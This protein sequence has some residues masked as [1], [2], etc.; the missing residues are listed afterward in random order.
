VK[1][2][3]LNAD[4]G[5][6]D[7]SEGYAS[8]A[9]ILAVV[10]SASIACGGHAGT[11]ATMRRAVTE[12]KRHHV[13]IGAHPAYPD[14]DYFGRRSG[15]DI[16]LHDLSRSLTEQIV[17][18]VEIAAEQGASVAYVKPHGAL[19]NDAVNDSD[20]AQL[21]VHT[22]KSLDP[23]LA[24][25]GAPGSDLDRAA[26]ASHLDFIP[27]GFID[28]R[29]A[30]NGH[31]VPRR[32]NGAVLA[33]DSER[34]TQMESLVRDGE[35]TTDTGG[36]ITLACATLCLHGDSPGA[37]TTAHAAR[38]RLEALGYSVQA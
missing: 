8:D 38:A 27:E 21:I 33:S 31:L 26:E 20:L 36:R 1:K 3:D 34:L 5:E 30:D 12:A 35:V 7:S 18:L 29:Y 22:V 19:Y 17:T 32:Q 9:A 37:M 25:M 15:F 24:L 10:S 28:R 14:P 13:R 16:S 6:M 4:L 11:P 2:I 23:N